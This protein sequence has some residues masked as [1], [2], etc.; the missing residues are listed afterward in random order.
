VTVPVQL[1][2]V[3][4]GDI[5][6]SGHLPA[7]ERSAGVRLVGVVEPDAAQRDWATDRYGVAGWRTLTDVPVAEVDAVVI[8]VPPEIAPVLTLTAIDLG[9]DVL[10]EKPMAVDL[11]SAARVHEAAGASGRVVQIGLKN[12]FSPLV[13]SV[14]DWLRDGR[15]GGPVAYTLGGFDERYD[16]RDSV[17]SGRIRHFLDHGPSF[18]HEGAHFADYL[19][20]LTGARPVRVQAAGVRSLPD[21]GADNF[22][23]ALVRYDNGDLARLEIGWMFPTAPAGEIRVLGPRG[24]ALLDRPNQVAELTERGPDGA[25]ETTTV[26]LQEPW[27]DVCFDR[28]LEHFVHCVRT[29]STPETSTSAG[30]ASLRL[31]LAVAEAG[32]TGVTIDLTTDGRPT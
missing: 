17:H 14:R 30:L 15:I 8:A 26:T 10:C 5:A 25:L 23:S 32:R 1:V 29:R 31:G 4:C 9:W 19:A 2:Q 16:P 24:V 6:R 27:N 7:I 3:G 13:R 11:A 12:R 28:Q 21:L 22:V 18:L 20:Y